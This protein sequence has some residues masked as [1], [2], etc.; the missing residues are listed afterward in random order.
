MRRNLYGGEGKTTSRVK[1]E[2]NAQKK[3][4]R[5]INEEG[6]LPLNKKQGGRCARGGIQSEK[7]KKTNKRK[8]LPSCF[9]FLVI[10]LNKFACPLRRERERGRVVAR[11]KRDRA[12]YLPPTPLSNSFKH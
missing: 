11:S 4:T 8:M 2:E 1:E 5:K 6:N 9:T 10:F 12:T 3:E 7:E